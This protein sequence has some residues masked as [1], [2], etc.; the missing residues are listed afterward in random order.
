MPYFVFGEMLAPLVEAV[1]LVLTILGTLSGLL[2]PRYAVAFFLVAYL[3]GIVLSLAAILMEE[4]SFHRYRRPVDSLRL[5]FY[6]LIEP[7]GYRQITVWF[8]LKAFARYIRGD[9]SWGRMNREGFAA[10]NQP[11]VVDADGP[12]VGLAGASLSD[13]ASTR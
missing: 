5:L 4:A 9:H 13:P 6:A 1:G 11:S 8:R 12:S 10:Q 3:Y 2:S 7:F